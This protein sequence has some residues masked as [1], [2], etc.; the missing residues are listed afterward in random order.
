MT[1]HQLNDTEKRALLDA[2]VD[3]ARADLNDGRPLTEMREA[4]Q[5]RPPMTEEQRELFIDASTLAYMA[6][7]FSG[8][9]KRL[10]GSEWDEMAD[11]FGVMLVDNLNEWVDAELVRRETEKTK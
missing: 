11:K 4:Q 6:I 2:V 3:R 7:R 1:T 5:P 9:Y 8:L 10:S